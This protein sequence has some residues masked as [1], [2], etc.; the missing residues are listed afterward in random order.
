MNE[1]QAEAEAEERARHVAAGGATIDDEFIALEHQFDAL[2]HK[3]LQ[4]HRRA[5][6]Q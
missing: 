6:K 2:K 1:A 5:N 4:L 3:L